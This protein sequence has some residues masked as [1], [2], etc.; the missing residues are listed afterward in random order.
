MELGRALGLSQAQI[1]ALYDGTWPE[2]DD[3]DARQKAAIRWAEE[4][5][6]L[7]AKR[8]PAAWAEMKAH[9]TE[10]QSSS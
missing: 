4:V 6:H 9:F 1:D 5:S 2:S 7:R 3:F 10:R 8:N